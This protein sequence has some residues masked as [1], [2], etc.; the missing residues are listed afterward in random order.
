LSKKVFKGWLTREG[1]LVA[2]AKSQ[3]DA[4]NGLESMERK[5]LNGEEVFRTDK[6][7]S[8]KVPVTI[9]WVKERLEHYNKREFVFEG[10]PYSHNLAY[11]N[12]IEW[13][14]VRNKRK[15]DPT[16]NN[17]DSGSRVGEKK[18][19]LKPKASN[20]RCPIKFGSPRGVSTDSEDLFTLNRD[21]VSVIYSPYKLD[22]RSIQFDSDWRG[23]SGSQFKGIS[24]E[25]MHRTEVMEANASLKVLQAKTGYSMNTVNSYLK[26]SAREL[27]NFIIREHYLVIGAYEEGVVTKINALSQKENSL[28]GRF[29]A[30]RMRSATLSKAIARGVSVEFRNINGS[31]ESVKDEPMLTVLVFQR[32]YYLINEVKEGFLTPKFKQSG[33]NDEKV[34]ILGDTT[35]LNREILT[36]GKEMCPLDFP[37]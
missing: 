26:A 21:N 16:S 23:K 4:V 12:T 11:A 35:P 28:R 15:G 22:K 19:T 10:A 33:E 27:D 20:A 31:I 17:T 8:E 34:V 3:R 30:R 32:S 18:N 14:A 13:Q 29:F 9:D 37:F 5:V 25:G 1:H 6:E 24:L 2:L 36:S 7:T